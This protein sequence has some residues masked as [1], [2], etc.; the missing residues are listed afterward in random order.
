MSLAYEN[1][2]DGLG[3]PS[4]NSSGQKLRVLDY[5][6]IV[7]L[8]GIASEDVMTDFDSPWKEALDAFF[9]SFLE[10][11]FPRARR[12]RL[13][14]GLESLDKELQKSSRMQKLSGGMWINL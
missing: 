9:Q 3:G 7:H 12:H 14:P 4:Y 10:L 2:M 8:S 6:R 5:A 13:E 11:F 1:N